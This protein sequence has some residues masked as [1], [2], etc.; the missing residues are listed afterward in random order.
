MFCCSAF[1]SSH[2]AWEC[3]EQHSNAAMNYQTTL[4]E[5][6]NIMKYVFRQIR[7][8]DLPTF[9]WSCPK[10]ASEDQVVD[11]RLQY[12]KV[13]FTA[14]DQFKL[15]CNMKETSLTTYITPI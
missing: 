7:T 1:S 11:L 12:H 9:C 8:H 6:S 15:S 4:Y 14:S 3:N 2:S 5:P 13:H 10:E